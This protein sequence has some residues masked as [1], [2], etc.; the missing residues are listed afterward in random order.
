MEARVKSDHQWNDVRCQGVEYVKGEFR[1]VP[2][3]DEAVAKANPGLEFKA[4]RKKA[5]PKKK[6]A[7]KKKA[8]AKKKVAAKK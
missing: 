3:G 4:V 6:A 5:A 8:P 1:L 2:E 7:A